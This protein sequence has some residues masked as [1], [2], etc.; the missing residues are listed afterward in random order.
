MLGSDG[1]HPSH[2][3][4]SRRRGAS[5]SSGFGG[6]TAHLRAPARGLWKADDGSVARDD[7]AILEVMGE[8]LDRAWWAEYRRT[9]ERRF[10]QEVMVV[11]AT[12]LDIL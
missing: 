4:S 6:L 7:V 2:T 5:W 3:S 1:G 12:R 8:G 10:R 9:L 11:R